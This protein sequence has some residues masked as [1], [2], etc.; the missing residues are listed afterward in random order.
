MTPSFS[1]TDT[2]GPGRLEFVAPGDGAQYFEARLQLPALECRAKIYG[3]NPTGSLVGVLEEL[4]R[5]WKGWQG[6]RR[7]SS[8]ES[9]LLLEFAHD[10][11][12]HVGVGVELRTYGPEA[13]TV[14]TKLVLEPG[15]LQELANQAKQFFSQLKTDV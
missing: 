10:G 1:L 6:A 9:D 11:I 8:I 13:W 12:G 7:W 5:N 3:Y 14:R 2:K 4:A 15:A